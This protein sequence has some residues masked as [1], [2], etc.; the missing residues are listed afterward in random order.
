MHGRDE[1]IYKEYCRVRNQIRRL[2]RKATKNFEKNIAGQA[3]SNPKKFWNYV[4][5]KTK[6]RSAIP[7]LITRDDQN[8]ESLTNGDQEKAEALAEFF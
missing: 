2:T 5:N 7:D 4:N 8:I 1:K 3:K 6:V